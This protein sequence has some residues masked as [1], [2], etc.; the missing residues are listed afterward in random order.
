MVWC[1]KKHINDSAASL[2]QSSSLV[3]NAHDQRPLYTDTT[4]YVI[5]I[6]RLWVGTWCIW[7]EPHTFSAVIDSKRWVL[8]RSHFFGR[9]FRPPPLYL[10]DITCWVRSA[11]HKR[12]LFGLLPLAF[13]LLTVEQVI[14]QEQDQQIIKETRVEHFGDHSFSWE[15]LV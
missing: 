13:L 11:D 14:E 12:D 4:G 1:V 3:C 8:C 6:H 10:S 5:A 2:L 15:Q 9:T 7:I